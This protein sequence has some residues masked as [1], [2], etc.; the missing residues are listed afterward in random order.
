MLVL[1]ILLVLFVASDIRFIAQYGI[2]GV[3]RSLYTWLAFGVLYAVILI[4]SCLVMAYAKNN[5]GV[6]KARYCEIDDDF[7]S[8]YLLDG[9]MSKVRWDNIVRVLKTAR[10]YLLYLSRA[11][12]L[13]L[14]VTA[15][16][17]EEDRTNFEHLLQHEL[18]F[19][20]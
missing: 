3:V 1:L 14:P 11:S 10:Y 8:T 4:A 2:A 17:T 19:S 7:F 20:G 18:S 15:F 6:L 5:Q 9:S 13:Y 12:F 16:A